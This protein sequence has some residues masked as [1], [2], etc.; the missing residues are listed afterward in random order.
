MEVDLEAQHK[1]LDELKTKHYD[2][3]VKNHGLAVKL[4]ELKTFRKDYV[5][6]TTYYQNFISS[7]YGG[8]KA[9]MM[10]FEFITNE[11]GQYSF[12]REFIQKM[13]KD[14]NEEDMPYRFP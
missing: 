6:I 11:R 5:D 8:D 10:N 13:S 9:S 7:F 14:P 1:L 2:E 4:E 3:Y 12:N